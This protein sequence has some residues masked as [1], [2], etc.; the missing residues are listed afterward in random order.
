MNAYG[1][2]DTTA[3]RASSTRLRLTTRGR[4]VL[5]SLA[6]LPVA[7]V[8]AVGIMSGGGAVASPE[9]GSADAFEVI[10]VLPGETLWSLAEEFAPGVDPRSVVDEIVRLNALPTSTLDAG[11]QISLPEQ[12]S[13]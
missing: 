1:T 8:F 9:A 4:R 13:K 6:A 5:A 10:T 11:Q 7:A 2:T 12:Y 3:A